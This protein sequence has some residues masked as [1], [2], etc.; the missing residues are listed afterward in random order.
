MTENVTST[1][2]IPTRYTRVIQR[3]HMAMT[4]NIINRGQIKEGLKKLGHAI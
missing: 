1:L 4:P 2:G 3:D